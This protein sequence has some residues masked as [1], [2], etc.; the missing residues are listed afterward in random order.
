M[1][2]PRQ[3]ILLGRFLREFI[4]QPQERDKYPDGVGKCEKR[5]AL[6][7][8][9]KALAKFILTPKALANL[10]PGLERSD[11][12]GYI[13][14]ITDNPER[15][16]QLANPFRVQAILFADPMVVASLQPWA[17][18][19]ERLWRKCLSSINAFGVYCYGKPMPNEMPLPPRPAAGLGAC[20][21][22][23]RGASIASKVSAPATSEMAV[24]R[25]GST[26]CVLETMI[27][28]PTL[29]STIEIVGNLSSMSLMLK[30]GRPPGPPGPPAP[31]G[32][33]CALPCAAGAP[34]AGA[35]AAPGAPPPGLIPIPNS[36]GNRLN[37]AS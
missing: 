36:A 28:S 17:E 31:W 15:V 25:V 19:S 22:C 8:T 13:R 18:I 30:P 33:C 6:I 11:N 27:V 3:Q 34:P 9:P 14:K 1:N 35:G 23:G 12:P 24:N 37:T 7:D 2:R 5:E 20:P 26:P 16:R 10:S 21:A 4:M 29:T 32:R